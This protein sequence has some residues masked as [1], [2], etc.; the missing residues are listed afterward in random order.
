[1]LRLAYEAQQAGG[2]AT[3]SLNAAD[4]I[5]VEAFLAGRLPFLGIAE[6]VA[7]TL[8]KMPHREARSVDEV[9]EIDHQS[10]QTARGLIEGREK[11]NVNVRI[12]AKA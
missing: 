11:G 10:R 5:A 2:S 9:L 8:E 12:R 3:C 6:I 4:E 1:M 7:E